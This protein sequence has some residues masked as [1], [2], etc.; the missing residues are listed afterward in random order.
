VSIAI[1][2]VRAPTAVSGGNGEASCRAKWC[3]GKYAPSAPSSSAAIASSTDCCSASA[4]VRVCEPGDRD[5][6][7]SE[8]NPIF[9]IPLATGTV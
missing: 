2:L 9:V 5:Q 6:W 1:R 7:P 4:A 3:T 8:R